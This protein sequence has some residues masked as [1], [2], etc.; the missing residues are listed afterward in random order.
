MHKR[1]GIH[2]QMDGDLT[3]R[4][5]HSLPDNWILLYIHQRVRGM[6]DVTTVQ[7]PWPK[8]II[9]TRPRNSAS[10][11]IKGGHMVGYVLSFRGKMIKRKT[12]PILEQGRE[13][14]S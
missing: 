7:R 2:W 12:A 4:H 5:Y 13:E 6:H 1:E 11:E 14:L 10:R 3:D 8:Y 9:F